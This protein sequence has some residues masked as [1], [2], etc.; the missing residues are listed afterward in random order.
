MK[1]AVAIAVLFALALA[2]YYY[3]MPD[4]GPPAAI[5]DST[6]QTDSGASGD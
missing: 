5:G 6:N 4:D 3:Q 2:V 1:K